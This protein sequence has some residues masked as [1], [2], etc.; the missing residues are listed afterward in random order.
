MA[1]SL[2]LCYFKTSTYMKENQ[3]ASGNRARQ[4]SWPAVRG[5]QHRGGSLSCFAACCCCRRVSRFGPTSCRPLKSEAT[6][7]AHPPAAVE[8]GPLGAE[9]SKPRILT[10]HPIVDRIGRGADVPGRTS[11][12]KSTQRGP[13]AH[14]CKKQARAA[15]F[16]GSFSPW[17]EAHYV[18]WPPLAVGPALGLGAVAANQSC[19]ARR[20]C[21]RAG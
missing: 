13:R 19:P 17:P 12:S 7:R 15:W 11:C 4:G 18:R 14:C 20:R 5:V 21:P 9:N 3:A 8:S 16:P 10:P 2:N 6:K 1:P